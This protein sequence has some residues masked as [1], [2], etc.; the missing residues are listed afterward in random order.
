MANFIVQ[1]E[2][3][4]YAEHISGSKNN[5]ADSLSREFDFTKNELTNLIFN[6]FTNQIPLNFEVQE[7]PNKTAYW[8]LSILETETFTKE[9][10]NKLPKK[11]IQTGKSGMTLVEKLESK[12]NFSK[13][14]QS[15]KKSISC[16]ASQLQSEETF[17]KTKERNIAWKYC[18][19]HSTTCSPDLQD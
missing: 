10:G 6:I 17:W 9:Q 12:M 7:I 3:S 18:P 8:I 11:Q 4:L 5:V 19:K 2:H 1:K 16:V 14:I 13:I 15:N